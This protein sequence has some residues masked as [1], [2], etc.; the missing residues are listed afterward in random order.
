MHSQPETADKSAKRNTA[1]TNKSGVI[2]AGIKKTGAR[3]NVVSKAVITKAAISTNGTVADMPTYME[4]LLAEMEHE[5]DMALER[6]S[7]VDNAEDLVDMGGLLSLAYDV[8]SNFSN[9]DP[10]A[11]FGR[12]G[13]MLAQVVLGNAGSDDLSSVEEEDDDMFDIAFDVFSDFAEEMED[14]GDLVDYIVDEEMTTKSSD[15]EM[16]SFED[17]DTISDYDSDGHN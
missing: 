3:K 1:S 11:L 9:G 16:A 10:T 8:K 14:L 15:E 12:D 6:M 2:N 17:A 4:T 13:S 7:P 5:F